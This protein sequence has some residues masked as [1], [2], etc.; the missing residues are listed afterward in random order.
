VNKNQNAKKNQNVKKNQ[1]ISVA[2]KR[3]K[4]FRIAKFKPVANKNQYAKNLNK[5]IIL[6]AMLYLINLQQ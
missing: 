6:P 1:R 2:N 3:K 5:K 4:R